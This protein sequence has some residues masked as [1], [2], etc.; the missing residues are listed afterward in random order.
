[1]KGNPP[2]RDNSSPYNLSGPKIN[3]RR[4][5]M[6]FL[7]LKWNAR[8]VC[9]YAGALASIPLVRVILEVHAFI[10]YQVQ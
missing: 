2:I 3:F 1:M 4:F 9:A 7:T 5:K 8:F 10:C 6:N